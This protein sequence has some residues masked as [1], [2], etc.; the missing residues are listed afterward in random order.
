MTTSRKFLILDA[1][2]EKDDEYALVKNIRTTKGSFHSQQT[3]IYR[4]KHLWVE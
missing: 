2:Q 3:K 1:K 4:S